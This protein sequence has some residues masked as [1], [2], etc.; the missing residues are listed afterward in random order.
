MENGGFVL[1]RFVMFVAWVVHLIG[2]VE[3]KKDVN[4]Q[5]SFKVGLALSVT[6]I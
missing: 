6:I 3:D 1:V 2:N 5:H 4:G